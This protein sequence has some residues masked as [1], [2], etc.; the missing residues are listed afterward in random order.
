MKI[1]ASAISTHEV[2]T[3]A[4][5]NVERLHSTHQFLPP[6]LLLLFLLLF[7]LSAPSLSALGEDR[8]WLLWLM[9]LRREGKEARWRGKMSGCGR[10]MTG[11]CLPPRTN[12]GFRVFRCSERRSSCE[13]EKGEERGSRMDKWGKIT[14]WHKAQSGSRN[15]DSCSRHCNGDGGGWGCFFT[16]LL[17]LW[18]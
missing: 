8:G 12:F 17:L 5:L 16:L 3:V 6:A 18:S 15:N 11:C 10:E 9:V 2:Q 1:N 7:M 4:V 13:L 14:N